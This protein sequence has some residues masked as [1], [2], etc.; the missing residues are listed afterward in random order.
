MHHP[1]TKLKAKY[2]FIYANSSLRNVGREHKVSK[3]S[4][5][6]WVKMKDADL[7]Y[8]A[9]RCRTKSLDQTCHSFV[10]E[11]LKKN[12]CSR[13]SDIQRELGVSRG[14]HVSVATIHRFV[15]NEL[16]HTWKITK[17]THTD[18]VYNPAHPFFHAT[19]DWSNVISIDETA[20][21]MG[22][23]CSRGW[24]RKGCHAPR[25]LHKKRQRMSALCAIDASGLVSH[26]VRSG[27]FNGASFSTFLEK[28]PRDSQILLDNVAFHKC[29]SVKNVARERN[30]TLIFIPPYSPWFNPI[31]LAFSQ[32]KCSFRRMGASECVSDLRMKIVRSLSSIRNCC[33]I[34]K[35]TKAL[36]DE[37]LKDGPFMQ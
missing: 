11:M 4:V 28:V 3:S 27:S 36:Y 10:A 32:V 19:I 22:A 26:E 16:M 35:H 20:F 7:L 18:A 30:Q 29:S 34:F 8:A 1:I 9:S 23:Q 12:P 21:Y 17:R 6:R 14:V 15:R 13:M 33:G 31:E 5:Q 25:T 37:V 24:S 2:Q